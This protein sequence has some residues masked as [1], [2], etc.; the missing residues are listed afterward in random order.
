MAYLRR[1]VASWLALETRESLR[2]AGGAFD[3]LSHQNNEMSAL[4][5]HVRTKKASLLHGY[6]IGDRGGARSKRTDNPSAF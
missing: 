2:I 4:T 6:R 5:V 1:R 3:T